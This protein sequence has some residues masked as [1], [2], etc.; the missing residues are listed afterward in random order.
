M[1]FSRNDSEYDDVSF[2][3][4]KDDSTDFIRQALTLK[5]QNK[6]ETCNAEMISKN[7]TSLMKRVTTAYIDIKVQETEIDIDVSGSCMP[8]FGSD[9]KALEVQSCKLCSSYCC[10]SSD[11]ERKAV[12]LKISDVQAHS[13][14]HVNMLIDSPMPVIQ[15]RGCM[16]A[17]WYCTII[18]TLREKQT[19]GDFDGHEQLVEKRM[20]KLKT[21]ADS[22]MEMSLRV[23]KAMA[24]YFQNNFKD[25]KKILKTVVK[26]EDKLRNPGIL[27]GR[28]LNLLTAVYKHEKKFG[29]AMECVERARA[30]LEGQDS[31]HD[32]AEL[33]HSYGALITA[34]PAARNP[35]TARII[36][37]EAYKSYQMADHYEFQNYHHIKM[38]A[39]LLESR[40]RGERIVNFPCKEDLMKAKNHLDFL[41]PKLADNIGLKI[42]FL[43]LRSDQY[44]YEGKV[45][46]AMEKAQKA[47]AL[48]HQHG[49]KLEIVYAK[50]RI[51]RLSTMLRQE[52]EV[53]RETELGYSSDTSSC[54]TESESA[55][56]LSAMIRQENEK[57]RETEFSSSSGTSGYCTESESTNS[58]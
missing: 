20:A 40:S 2:V 45:A 16:N 42:R 39:L 23:E 8:Q 1:A 35:E 10:S 13:H 5:Q 41:E 53:W 54:S 36:K 33:H 27:V 56:C 57:W 52:N 46:I 21:D 49:F 34:M 14:A 26:H 25:A 43:L 37:E 9:T 50:S 31:A 3:E 44:L 7:Y 51:D 22:D 38:A 24:L 12:A 19:T 58:D 48:I 4:F 32:K 17:F 28:A 11:K 30:C 29:N 18:A 47:S 15:K 55:N 6:E